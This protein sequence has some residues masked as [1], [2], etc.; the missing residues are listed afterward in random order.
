ME[1]TLHMTEEVKVTV[2]DVT[3]KK[4]ET[5]GWECSRTT[6]IKIFFSFL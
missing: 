6:K 4:K 3:E 1:T 2:T 5:F